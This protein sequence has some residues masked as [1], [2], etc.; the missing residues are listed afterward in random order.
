MK[1]NFAKGINYYIDLGTCFTSF[2]FARTWKSKEVLL[3]IIIFQ[4]EQNIVLSFSSIFWEVFKAVIL[5]ECLNFSSLILTTKLNPVK[6]E[7]LAWIVLLGIFGMII[8]FETVPMLFNDH[9]YTK[10]ELIMI[11]SFFLIV[12]PQD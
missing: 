12:I 8:L 11:F 2:A 7:H 6:Y 3:K 10:G 4:P 5:F 9:G 1:S